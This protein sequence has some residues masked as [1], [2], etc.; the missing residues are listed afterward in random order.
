MNSITKSSPV[1]NAKTG[2][3]SYTWDDL[4]QEKLLCP[5]CSEAMEDWYTRR[6]G[7]IISGHKYIFMAPRFRCTCSRTMTMRPYFIAKRKQYSV[8]DIQEI[9]NAD[10]SGDHTASTSYGSS[11]VAG[12]RR[13]AVALVKDLVTGI[14]MAAFRNERHVIHTLKQ[15]YGNLWLSSILMG[16]SDSISFFMQ[17]D[18]MSAKPHR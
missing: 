15:R 1:F 5:Q 2:V 18:R 16:S 6:R 11:M 13:W 14:H 12:L 3:I 8:F 9:L 17:A 10:A 4:V 7:V